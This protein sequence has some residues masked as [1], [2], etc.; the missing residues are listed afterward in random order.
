[1]SPRSLSTPGKEVESGQPSSE[2]EARPSHTSEIGTLKKLP[3][4]GTA[5]L[6]SSSGVYFV[7][8]VRRAFS[9]AFAPNSSN[10]VPASEDILTGEDGDGYNY[11]GP[12]TTGPSATDQ[13]P[14]FFAAALGRP[15]ERKM[16]MELVTRFFEA[17]HPLF[18]FL[19]GPSFLKDLESLYRQS[20]NPIDSHTSST[21]PDVRKAITF[22]LVI[23][24]AS[25]DRNDI[26]LPEESR[27]KSTADVARVA[28]LI[29]L[30][31]GLATIQALLAANLYLVATMAIRHAST[32]SGIIVKL[33]YH[34][35]LHRCPLRYAQL[36]LEDCEIRK[37]IF[38]SAYALDRHCN[39]S[40][41]DPN[42][43]Q[44]D[45]IDVCL[46]GR[47]LHK[48][49]ARD[50]LD[51]PDQEI[52]SNTAG[53]RAGPANASVSEDPRL[54]SQGPEA[55]Q[56]ELREAALTAFVRWGKLTGNIIEIFH[57]SINHRFP[58]QEQILYLTSDIESWWN[59]LPGFLTGEDTTDDAPPQQHLSSFFKILYHR[60]LLLVSRP[61]LSLDQSTPEFQHGLQVCIRASRNILRGLKSHQEHGQSM[62]LP[63]LLSAAWMSG[64]IIA[65]ACQ[66]G[67]YPKNRACS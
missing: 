58:K 56:K 26:Q 63:G 28:G 3:N 8:T 48:A 13:I 39:L 11:N 64:L 66:L 35:G 40:L 18:P 53:S 42:T 23:N 67:K 49:V 37:R 2:D 31:H 43:I 36:S 17:W 32:V 33:I 9:A 45:D 12:L 20:S 6:G 50:H 59:E 24:I 38:W 62:F 57:K 30:D 27:I 5:W 60:L 61:K 22:Q 4:Q 47:E 65:F 7:N 29:A 46:S 16:A 14:R 44:D 10:D 19:H 21:S 41:G 34:A 25:L 55:R 54:V 15:P 51:K 52:A 1:M